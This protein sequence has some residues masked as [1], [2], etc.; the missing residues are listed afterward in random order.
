MRNRLLPGDQYDAIALCSMNAVELIPWAKK[1]YRCLA[2]DIQNAEERREYDGG[3]FIDFSGESVLDL[4]DDFCKGAMLAFAF[5]PCTDLASSGARW[6]KAKEERAPGTLDRAVCFAKRCWEL[7]SKA[8]AY[9]LENPI[10][11]LATHWRKPDEKFDPYEYGGYN[12]G[13]DAYTKKTCLWTGGRWSTP[14]KMP[15][16]PVLGSKMHRMPGGGRKKSRNDRSVTPRGWANAVF[17]HMYG[18]CLD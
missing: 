2:V 10:G 18:R 13:Q 17:E 12:F 16:E 15:V 3:G 11:R 4:P 6:W 5:P 14:P 1:G 8:N 7:I 9:A